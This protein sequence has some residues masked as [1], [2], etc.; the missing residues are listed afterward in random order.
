MAAGLKMSHISDN[1]MIQKL[2]G[3]SYDSE[4]IRDLTGIIGTIRKNRGINLDDLCA[5]TGHEYS[6]TMRLAGILEMEGIITMDLL[7]RCTI[8][9][10]K[11]R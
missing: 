11:S 5:K 4:T 1:D 2:L 3:S 9:I 6:K 10:R 7:Q 8:N